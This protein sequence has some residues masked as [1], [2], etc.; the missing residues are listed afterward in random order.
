MAAA[1]KGGAN[2]FVGWVD[3]EM[4]RLVADVK[5]NCNRTAVSGG[6]VVGF[7][8]STGTIAG[9]GV[10]DVLVDGDATKIAALANDNIA[11]G[12][13]L[14]RLDTYAVMDPAGCRVGPPA[15]P[16]PGAISITTP[17]GFTFPVDAAGGS[18]PLALTVNAVG[19]AGAIYAALGTANEPA[20]IYQNL[21]AN[22]AGNALGQGGVWFL[23]DRTTATGTANALQMSD[24]AAV[25]TSNALSTV[26]AATTRQAITLVQLQTLM[27]R[28]QLAS[29]DAPDI[30]LVN[31]LQRTR[32]AA[33]LQANVQFQTRVDGGKPGTGDGGF[34]DFAFAGIP[35]KASRHMDNGLILALSTKHWKM[36]ELEAGK[37][38][39]EDGNVLSRVGTR[40]A[41]EGFYK[42]YYNTVCTRP[43]ANG[44][45]AGLTL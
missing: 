9:A 16:A 32:L 43:N 35:V 38:A 6:D 3:G 36:C 5:N 1:G 45:I 14:V 18:V 4:N 19:A 29:D 31:P 34:S 11:T 27:D 22:G 37:F 25:P 44:L 40:D 28:I 20:G 39:D 33:M 30:L 7:V 24:G 13:H 2:S 8:T 10:Q 12:V 42:W 21:G 41:Y 23:V 26:T 15:V 17:T